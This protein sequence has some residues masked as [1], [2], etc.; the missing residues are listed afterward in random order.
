M[1][2]CEEAKKVKVR[3]VLGI[4]K[5]FDFL[6]LTTQIAVFQQ[7]VN[8]LF[9]PSTDATRFTYIPPLHSASRHTTKRKKIHKKNTLAPF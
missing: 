8:S 9:T 7:P 1:A 6:S 2:R 5:Q 4:H 3:S